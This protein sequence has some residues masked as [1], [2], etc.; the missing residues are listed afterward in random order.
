MSEPSPAPWEWHRP[1]GSPVR[2]LIS[3]SKANTIVVEDAAELP[4]EADAKM[5]A[6][7]PEMLSLLAEEFD[8]G[9]HMFCGGECWT[10]RRNA[11]LERLR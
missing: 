3:Q 2:Y 6:A 11:L 1:Y 4:S 8:D 5:I 10:C 9:Q 7:A